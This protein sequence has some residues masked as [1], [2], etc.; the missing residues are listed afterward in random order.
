MSAP[1]IG[2]EI[3]SVRFNLIGANFN[4]PSLLAEEDKTKGQ[5]LHF[6]TTNREPDPALNLNAKNKWIPT[7]EVQIN[8]R[9]IQLEMIY[10]GPTGVAISTSVQELGTVGEQM[11]AFL[12]ALDAPKP[13]VIQPKDGG[14][15][16]FIRPANLLTL[17]QTNMLVRWEIAAAASSSGLGLHA[18]APIPLAALPG[19][20]NFEKNTK[21][22]LFGN[23]S[24]RPLLK[25]VTP[26][27]VTTS[28]FNLAS[29]Q[30]RA[31]P[32]GKVYGEKSV[33]GLL[34]MIMSYITKAVPSPSDTDMNVKT[35]VPLMP[36]TDFITMVDIVTELVVENSPTEFRHSLVAIV[37]NLKERGSSEKSFFNW[38]KPSFKVPAVTEGPS[39]A[40]PAA[41]PPPPP[42]P[43][44]P[45]PGARGQGLPTSNVKGPIQHATQPW[46]LSVQSWLQ[47]L[48]DGK[49]DQ[50]ALKDAEFRGSKSEHWEIR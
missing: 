49:A 46:N 47:D 24:H 3:E 30:W 38:Q 25:L 36:R 9:T 14:G 34:V 41:A 32:A 22:I 26:E 23:T 10:G 27:Q 18:T 13:P 8:L 31:G 17:S 29:V 16:A 28:G 11:C 33:A 40:I 2:F 7:A 19:L 35:L 21:E 4:E 37:Q 1:K 44:Q 48:V 42:P 45:T 39:Q 15:K 20:V 12:R 50:I 5:L 43:P 6:F